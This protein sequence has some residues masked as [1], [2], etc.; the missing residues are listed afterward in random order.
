LVIPENDPSQAQ[1]ECTALGNAVVDELKG[2]VTGSVSLS[3]FVSR[4]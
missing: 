4:S 3:N 2:I 1:V